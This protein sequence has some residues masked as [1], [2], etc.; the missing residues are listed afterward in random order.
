MLIAPIFL[1]TLVYF[2]LGDAPTTVKVA[3]INAPENY[4][5]NLE[6][7]NVIV[8][9]ASE[10]DARDALEQRRV[11]A[12]LKMINGKSTIEVDGSNPT[13]AK[14]AL[15]AL[16]G[17]KANSTNSMMTAL[18]ADLRSDV[19]Y[20]Y[21]TEDLSTFDN[22]GATLIGFIVFF[23]VFLVAG[24]SFLQE[25]T[26]GTLEK[27]LSMPLRRWEIVVGYVL[28]FGLFTVLQS[29]I[30]SWYCVYILKVMMVGSF[31]LVILIT[32]LAA[33]VALTLGILAST[34]A[35]N[36]FQMMQ[37]IP[38]V[39][40]PQLF[41]SGLFDLPSSIQILGRTMPLYYVSDALTQVMLRG[42]G[43][44]MIAGDL[45]ILLGCALLFMILNTLMLKKYRR[46]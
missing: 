1:I 20:I 34:A 22:F 40:I 15:A 41:F 10:S 9:R 24:I 8:T 11:V 44:S 23:F 39:I 26:S 38:I 2:I 12:T 21:G 13:K 5:Q 46:I 32:L 31:A 6:K 33:I 45:V 37:F 36:E 14:L 43:L 42:S 3:V 18:R 7:N 19:K 17:A 4:I 35:S 29:L 16:E 28:G 25:R 27:L 30:F